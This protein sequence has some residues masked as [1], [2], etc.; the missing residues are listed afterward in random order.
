MYCFG[1]VRCE[2]N[3]FDRKKKETTTLN[4]SIDK[5]CT[6][7]IPDSIIEEK[8]DK[9]DPGLHSWS[10]SVHCSVENGDRIFFDYLSRPFSE[11]KKNTPSQADEDEQEQEKERD[12]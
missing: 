1:L 4:N 12:S 8:T 10:R 2:S 9:P 11:E 7:D 6:W 3:K 5:L